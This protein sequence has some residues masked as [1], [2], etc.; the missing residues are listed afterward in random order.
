MDE[1]KAR[2]LIGREVVAEIDKSPTVYA[3]VTS[4][5]EWMFFKSSYDCISATDTCTLFMD[6]GV[7]T[8]NSVGL[9]VS[10]LYGILTDIAADSSM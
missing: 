5:L 8:K 2:S 3:V 4:Y 6:E 1:G 9:I 7:P 10:Y